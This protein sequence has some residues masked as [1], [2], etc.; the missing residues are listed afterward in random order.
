MRELFL[1]TKKLFGRL[2][3]YLV[4]PTVEQ[5]FWKTIMMIV[6]DQN[7]KAVSK[8]RHGVK[9]CTAKNRATSSAGHEK[10]ASMVRQLL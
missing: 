5:L 7:R 10:I 6:R 1:C 8:R 4:R 3:C 9:A 2:P